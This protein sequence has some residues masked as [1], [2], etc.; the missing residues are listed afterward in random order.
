MLRKRRVLVVDDRSSIVDV[1][2]IHFTMRGFDVITAYSGTEALLKATSE[3]P[4]VVVLDLILPGLTGTEVLRAIKENPDT[5]SIPVIIMTAR[6]EVAGESYAEVEG[7][8]GFLVKPF[9]LDQLEGAVERALTAGS[10]EA[11]AGAE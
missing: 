9:D 1:L 10:A 7:A 8:A 2:R 6:A 4:D 3:H 11:A 5:A